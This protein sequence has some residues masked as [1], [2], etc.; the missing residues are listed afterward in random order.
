MSGYEYTA[1]CLSSLLFMEYSVAVAV[2][3][4]PIMMP[5]ISLLMPCCSIV[6]TWEN[7][8]ENIPYCYLCNHIM[9]RNFLKKNTEG[10]FSVFHLSLFSVLKEGKASFSLRFY[11]II[12]TLAISSDFWLFLLSNKHAHRVNDLY[13]NLKPFKVMIPIFTLS[14]LSSNSVPILRYFI[15]PP[16]VSIWLLKEI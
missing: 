12:L 10:F 13:M 14:F 15:L 16:I 1:V 9:H 3:A 4:L 5:W 8:C 7:I 6:C 2:M 11:S